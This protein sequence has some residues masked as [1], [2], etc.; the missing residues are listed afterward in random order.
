[1]RY[2][3]VDGYGRFRRTRPLYH[4]RKSLALLLQRWY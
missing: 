4:C 3:L 1:M 2:S